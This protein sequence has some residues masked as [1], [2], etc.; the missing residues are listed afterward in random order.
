MI[1]DPHRRVLELRQRIIESMTAKEVEV[2]AREC[3]EHDHPTPERSSLVNI[4][5]T[6]ED[7]HRIGP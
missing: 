3:A 4:A 2:Y 6:P 5:D 1:Y 7:T